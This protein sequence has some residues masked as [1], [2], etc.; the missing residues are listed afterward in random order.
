MAKKD[1]FMQLVT[2]KPA[3]KSVESP[4]A[5]S[6]ALLRSNS[7]E[8]LLSE[9]VMEF[10][11]HN[12]NYPVVFR[13]LVYLLH[14][15]GCRISEALSVTPE[16]VVGNYRIRLKGS[17]GSNDRVV[18]IPEL[19]IG[20]L[21]LGSSNVPIWQVYSRFYVYR[22]LKQHGIYLRKE[23]NKNKAVTHAFRNAYAADLQNLVGSSELKSQAMGHKSLKSKQYYERKLF[24]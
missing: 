20:N 4:I 2:S 7:A 24:K 14:I 18:F 23:G 19:P 6:S 3:S 8:C 16:A 12:S 15:S 21:V 13:Y 10:V 11:L 17:K 9:L 1:A 22:V 5:Q